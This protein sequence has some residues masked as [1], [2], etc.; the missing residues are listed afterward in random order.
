MQTCAARPRPIPVFAEMGSVNPVFLLPGALAERGDQIAL[1]YSQSLTLGAGQFCTN[2]GV[3]VGL[4]SPEFD[5]FLK[6]A[7]TALEAV[8]CHGMLSKSIES[9]YVRGLE[10]HRGDDR[11]QPVVV[12]VGSQPALFKTTFSDLAKDPGLGDE[13]FGPSGLAVEC[14]TVE[15]MADVCELLS[16]QLTT[17]VFYAGADLE[18][19]RILLPAM[20]AASGRVVANSFPTGV[21]V[22]PAMHHG[23][24]YP[25]TSDSRS[26][27]VGT[28]AILRFVRPVV[29][30][31]LAP[32]LLPTELQNE[33]QRDSMRLVD[34]KLMRGP[35]DSAPA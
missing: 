10:R 17:T 5:L 18:A 9:A 27:S 33:N 30:Q 31:D 13:L 19:V 22:C 2:P 16:G 25:A 24:P 6:R 11:L 3:V 28:A 29:Y 4:R 26:T 1:G 35:I 12:G 14:E 32:E 8:T 21:E 7:G 20:T 15:E 23:G 34:G